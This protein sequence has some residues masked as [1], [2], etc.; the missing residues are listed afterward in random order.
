MALGAAVPRRLDHHVSGAALVTIFELVTKLHSLE[1]SRGTV[2]GIGNKVEGVLAGIAGGRSAHIEYE[3]VHKRTA[4]RDGVEYS[5]DLV[6]D[7]YHGSWMSGTVRRCTTDIVSEQ[8]F[9]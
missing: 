5:S 3:A 6:N 1:L 9:E 8:V 7:H 2:R 4:A